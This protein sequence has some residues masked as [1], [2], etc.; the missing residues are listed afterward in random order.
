VFRWLRRDSGAIAKRRSVA[1]ALAGYPPYEPPKWDPAS[2]SFR[3]ANAEYKQFFFDQRTYRLEEL[4]IFL[5]KFNVTMTLEDSAIMN[6]S[7]WYPMYADLLVDHLDK[8]MVWVAYHSF[9]SPWTGSFLG[10]NPIFDLGIYFGECMLSLNAR[11]AWQPGRGP[12]QTF[13]SHH[14][15]GRR[16]RGPFDPIREIYNECR[17][18]QSQKKWPMVPGAETLLEPDSLYRAIHGRARLL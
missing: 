15:F 12:E 8:E 10:L 14:I 3:D 17:N 9:E 4:R 16:N 11:L 18:I 2:K 13:V 7:R 5:E 6:V 1:A